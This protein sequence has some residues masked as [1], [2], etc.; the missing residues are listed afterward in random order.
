MPALGNQR[1]RKHQAE[2]VVNEALAPPTGRRIT[3]RPV[4]AKAGHRRLFPPEVH[5]EFHVGRSYG[6]QMVPLAA[7]PPE[8]S[9][10]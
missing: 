3:C 4:I 7:L 6:T 10:S 8:T 5:R 2:G 1:V 9:R